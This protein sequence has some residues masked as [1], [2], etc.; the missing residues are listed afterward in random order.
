MNTYIVAQFNLPVLYH[1]ARAG[2]RLSWFSRIYMGWGSITTHHSMGHE[3]PATA[4]RIPFHR[5]FGP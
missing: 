3:A 2:K 5:S 4:S 1:L